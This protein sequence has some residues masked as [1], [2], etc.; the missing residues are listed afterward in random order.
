MKRSIL[1]LTIIALCVSLYG[2]HVELLNRAGLEQMLEQNDDTVYVVNF[3]ATWCSPCIEEIGYFQELYSTY[4]NQKV[5]IILI[6]L[7]FPNQVEKRVL[8]FLEQKGIT[9]PVFSMTELDYNSWIP[10]V[11]KEWSG[12]IPATL[13]LHGSNR[14]F[15]AREVSRKEI[16]AQVEEEL[17]KQAQR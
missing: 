5:S 6:N 13:F 9:A 7:D 15:I 16:F 10:L 4:K 3:W 12:A 11:D 14:K 2:Q 1:I 8:P 17:N